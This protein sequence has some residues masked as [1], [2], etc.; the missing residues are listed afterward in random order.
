M[1]VLWILGAVLFTVA[2]TVAGAWIGHTTLRNRLAWL[3]LLLLL[4]L[5][6]WGAAIHTNAAG[7]SIGIAVMVAAASAAIGS[8]VAEKENQNLA[9]RIIGIPASLTIWSGMFSLVCLAVGESSVV[10]PVLHT[11]LPGTMVTSIFVVVLSMIFAALVARQEH[12]S[13]RPF[14]TPSEKS[15]EEVAEVARLTGLLQKAIDDVTDVL[16]GE[17]KATNAEALAT[18]DLELMKEV[19]GS[20]LAEGFRDGF[21]R[22]IDSFAQKQLDAKASSKSATEA[23]LSLT[24][25]H[26]Q[27]VDALVEEASSS[28]V[29]DDNLRLLVEEAK[30][31]VEYV[32]EDVLP[33]MSAGTESV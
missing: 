20:E 31:L 9:I 28:T 11:L 29:S 32:R 7:E 25:E 5:A 6:S 2:S 33:T 10:L 21:Q 4:S 12:E 24:G 26:F 16:H 15:A 8:I 30:L 19:G 13:A 3:G 17:Y 14:P 27:R 18:R 22:V 1:T 23:V